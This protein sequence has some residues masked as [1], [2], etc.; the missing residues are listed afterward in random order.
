[1][2]DILHKLGSFLLEVLQTVVLALSIFVISYLFLFQPHQVRGSSM[3]QNFENDDYLLTDKITYRFRQPQR[4]EIIVFKAPPSEPCALDDCEYIKRIIGLPGETIEV[5]D[6]S[7][8]INGQKLEENYIPL[9]VKTNPGAYLTE[10]KKVTLPE[11]GYF[12]SGDN[13]VYSHDSRAF[14]LISKTSIIG[15]AWLRYWPISKLGLVPKATYR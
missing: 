3:A 14:G 5:K 11:D 13:R 7:Y 15:K 8:F 12:L 9:S 6:G 4:G 10:S 1:M 2:S